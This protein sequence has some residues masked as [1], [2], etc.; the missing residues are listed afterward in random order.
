MKGQVSFIG[1]V[2]K[3]DEREGTIRVYPDFCS[4]LRGID[5]FSHLI[6][7]Y[8]L[9]QRDNDVERNV[10]LVYPRRH[11]VNVATGV[12]ACR[13]PSR[14]T[15]IAL[16]VVEILRINGCTLTVKGLDALDGSP[17]VDIKPYLPRSDSIPNA[18]VPEWTQHGPAT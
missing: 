7:L 2:E 16:C 15:P 17:I 4:G 9:H 14:P 11:S 13:S 1:V 18:R 10:L 3:A 8:W 12:F 6:I 5:A